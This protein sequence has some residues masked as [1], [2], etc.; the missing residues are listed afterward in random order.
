MASIAQNFNAL[1][2]GLAQ[3]G[4][5]GAVKVG[6]G[7][8]GVAVGPLDHE[9]H[10]GAGALADLGGVEPGSDEGIQLVV[11]RRAGAPFSKYAKFGSRWR[12]AASVVGRAQ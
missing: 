6:A 8:E 7:R 3:T 11:E 1:R 4:G 2:G 9:Q 12:F 10:D 5:M